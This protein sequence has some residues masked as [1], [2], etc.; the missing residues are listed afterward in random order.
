VLARLGLKFNDHIVGSVG[1]RN[2]SVDYKNAGF[3]FDTSMRGL[4]LDLG[5]RF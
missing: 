4:V 3:A 5:L 2:L 1:Y